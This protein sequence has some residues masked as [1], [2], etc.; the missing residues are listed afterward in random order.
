[1]TIKFSRQNGAD[2][3]A[4][5]FLVLLLAVSRI[6]VESKGLLSHS[7]SACPS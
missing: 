2:S 1:M 7:Q 5:F 6:E 3:R 4:R